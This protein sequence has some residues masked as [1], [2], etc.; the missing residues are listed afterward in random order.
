[1]QAWCCDGEV[2]S[3]QGEH[4]GGKGTGTGTAGIQVLHGDK[5][6]KKSQKRKE[7]RMKTHIPSTAPGGR[8]HGHAGAAGGEG[9]RRCR[10]G[11][12]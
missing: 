8:A 11:R 2:M 6:E 10:W 4:G 1:M 12:R 3:Q 9:A 5:G 7:K